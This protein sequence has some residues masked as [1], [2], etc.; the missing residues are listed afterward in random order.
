MRHV[1]LLAS[2]L[3][4][5]TASASC[6]RHDSK[7]ASVV[8]A[9]AN[10]RSVATTTPSPTP[11]PSNDYT[12]DQ[13]GEG[14]T[15]AENIEYTGEGAL[16]EQ[17][18]EVEKRVRKYGATGY[19][20]EIEYAVL[21]RNGRVIFRF[22]DDSVEQINEVRFGLCNFLGEEQRQLVVEETSNKFWRYWVL[23]LSPK[24]E[25]VYDS[26]RYDLVYPLRSVDLDG[27]GRLEIV[28]N[29]G[30]FWYRLGD[31]VSS[32][33]PEMIFKYDDRA[34]RYVPANP[35]FQAVVLKDIGHRVEKVRALNERNQPGVTDLQ[36]QSGVGDIVIRYL[37][38]GRERE[39]WDFFERGYRDSE[40]KKSARATL[41][42]VLGGDALYSE[43]VRRQRKR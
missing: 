39:A 41:K 38:A 43:V 16:S 24:L 4:I 25:V 5:V 11:T 20:T 36:L 6:A 37:Y 32:P 26:G 10:A 3:L 17:G 7:R 12:P 9:D 31:N 1:K 19:R 15:A 18:Y 23:R 28:Q 33:R 13:F 35:E 21:K 29:L 40:I 34:R 2:L 27:D 22:D 42:E 14:I 8:A 30:S